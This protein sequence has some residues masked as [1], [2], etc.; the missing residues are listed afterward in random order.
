L[1]PDI[2]VYQRVDSDDLRPSE[3][4]DRDKWFSETLAKI[5]FE[6]WTDRFDKGLLRAVVELLFP[7]ASSQHPSSAN[8]DFSPEWVSGKQLTF[9]AS[10]S[11]TQ[12]STSGVCEI[13]TS[14]DSDTPTDV[15][16]SNGDSHVNSDAE[17]SSDIESG[18]KR[19]HSDVRRKGEMKEDNARLN[20]LAL[21]SPDRVECMQF[22][23]ELPSNL[24]PYY[25]PPSSFVIPE[26]ETHTDLPS[27]SPSSQVSWLFSY[28]AMPNDTFTRVSSL[29]WRAVGLIEWL[30]ISHF[31]S[32]E[33]SFCLVQKFD[34]AHFRQMAKEINLRLASMTNSPISLGSRSRA[35]DSP[36]HPLTPNSSHSTRR[37]SDVVIPNDSRRHST[38][39]TQSQ[40]QSKS[41]KPTLSAII[42]SWFMDSGRPEDESDPQARKRRME[43][44]FSEN[45]RFINDSVA[46]IRK[47]N[48]PGVF[49]RRRLQK[50]LEEEI[51]R[52]LTLALTNGNVGHPVPNDRCHISDVFLDSW[53]Q[54]KAYVW[55][56]NQL[57]TGIRQSCRP[58]TNTFID[59]RGDVVSAVGL[60]SAFRGLFTSQA[61]RER[62][63]RGGICSAFS[64][65]E[66]AHTHRHLLPKRRLNNSMVPTPTTP[67]K[68]GTATPAFA[69][70]VPTSPNHAIIVNI[71]PKIELRENDNSETSG[72]TFLPHAESKPDSQYP[73]QRFDPNHQFSLQYLRDMPDFVELSQKLRTRLAEAFKNSMA[74]QT[75][76]V[77]NTFNEAHDQHQPQHLGAYLTREAALRLS[78]RLLARNNQISFQMTQ[79]K[80]A[81]SRTRRSRHF[82]HSSHTVD[83][84]SET[85][86]GGN[87][88][89]EHYRESGNCREPIG[90]S[91]RSSVARRRPNTDSIAT[92]NVIN[93]QNS[94]ASQLLSVAERKPPAE[95][96]NGNLTASSEISMDM[97][98]DVVLLPP[99]KSVVSLG[100]R[101]RH[102]RLF[103]MASHVS[104]TVETAP[105]CISVP[106]LRIS[107]AE[108][109]STSTAR[110][111][112]TSFTPES[113]SEVSDVSSETTNLEEVGIQDLKPDQLRSKIGQTY[114]FEEAMVNSMESKLWTSMQFWEDL[115][116]DTVAQERD[117]MGM[118]FD[119]T[120]QLQHYSQLGT[121]SKKSL[122]L[123]EDSLLT[124]VMH[125]LIAFMVMAQVPSDLIRRKIRRLIAKSHT[126]LHYTQKITHLLDCLEWLR[127][128]DIDLLPIGSRQNAPE[129]FSV[130]LECEEYTKMRM[131]EIYADF[132]L[133]RSMEGD[134]LFRWWYDEIINVTTS[135]QQSIIVFKVLINK[136]RRPFLVAAVDSYTLFTSIARAINQ[137]RA[138][139]PQGK[140]LDKLGGNVNV[141]NKETGEPGNIF[142]DPNGFKITFG[143]KSHHI[144]LDQ[145]KMCRIQDEDTFSFEVAG[146]DPDASIWTF[147]TDLGAVLLN[148]WERLISVAQAKNLLNAFSGVTT[149]TSPRSR[150][151]STNNMNT[152]FE[153]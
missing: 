99:F 57:S 22:G 42:D 79:Q 26:V 90:S 63:A 38:Q 125:N 56:F 83:D 128:N 78:Q 152:V 115:F 138:K 48:Q 50:L 109:R 151:S 88:G 68:S 36:N 16:A 51:Y 113:Q 35:F 118:D 86:G 121:I 153:R 20:S 143:S 41:T 92:F 53:D 104:P 107:L 149:P 23:K 142:L 117:L 130:C 87:W 94:T 72:K 14:S 13:E 101:Y 39:S 64:L 140:I 80:P 45:Q 37:I 69:A 74:N 136:Q 1:M 95:E 114:L 105:P 110:R 30:F 61:E 150:T 89:L 98:E 116:L 9:K 11:A 71:S 25:T 33:S 147:K 148:Q 119:P 21:R 31:S 144:P 70:S 55:L 62:L 24:V 3:F 102:G 146:Q 137:A 34:F 97:V 43:L 139:I 132:F 67:K 108:Q 52:N 82:L 46:L 8:H 76:Q 85:L 6:L 47:G 122:E 5:P 27:A 60:A 123:A 127:G 15:S 77:S 7:S 81:R 126:G 29:V 133:I 84:D 59:S 66:M 112:S 18:E 103:Q 111:P 124:G 135:S 73:S 91:R 58:L 4:G 44:E 134:V 145:V 10:P 28:Y 54:Y 120:G 12:S 106:T 93:T 100:Y 19:G 49:S 65:L 17:H 141:V 96:G 2:T 131:M 40:S 75:P 32:F 129:T